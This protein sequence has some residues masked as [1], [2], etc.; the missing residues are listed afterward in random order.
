MGVTVIR[1][2]RHAQVPGRVVP[3]STLKTLTPKPK[4]LK[5]LTA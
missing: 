1:A 2:L 5:A 3:E 4:N